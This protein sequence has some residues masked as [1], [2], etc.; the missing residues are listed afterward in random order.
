LPERISKSPESSFQV[1]G[2]KFKKHTDIEDES[3]PEDTDDNVI[4]DIKA[5][6]PAVEEFDWDSFEQDEM[7]NSP[8]HKEYEAMYDETLSTVA[9]DE[10]VTGTVFR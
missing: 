8:K 1:S 6:V 9:V 2:K 4:K 10:V 3:H 7:K 5:I